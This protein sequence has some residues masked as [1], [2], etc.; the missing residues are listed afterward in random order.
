M[1]LSPIYMLTAMTPL[2][3]KAFGILGKK[4]TRGQQLLAIDLPTF[5]S[6]SHDY[7]RFAKRITAASSD[8]P[9]KWLICARLAS[10]TMA[11]SWQEYSGFSYGVTFL[12]RRVLIFRL[13]ARPS[14]W[15]RSC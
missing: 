3:A 9:G 12:P 1:W 14:R 7:P 13:S 6:H 4:S 8:R 11:N 15:M 2:I 5:S 10:K